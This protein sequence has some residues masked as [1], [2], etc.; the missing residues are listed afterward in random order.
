MAYA[1]Y[2][3]LLRMV[4]LSIA[5]FPLSEALQQTE[6]MLSHMVKKLTGSYQIVYNDQTIDFT[7]PFKRVRM[8]QALE[9]ALDVK[10]S[11]DLDSSDMNA[12]L[13][14]LCNKHNVTCPPPMTNA[15][16]LDKLVGAF[17]ESKCINPT[18]VMDHPIIMSPLARN[19]R[20]CSGKRATLRSRLPSSGLTIPF[21][22]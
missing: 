19:H 7:P 1:D 5:L 8:I 4:E 10:L 9:D 22:D 3:D 15:R 20:N 13:L 14:D 12:M 21:Q 17:V 11:G 16:L 18:F 6:D 2:E